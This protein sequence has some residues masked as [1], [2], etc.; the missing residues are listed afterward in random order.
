[1]INKDPASAA[2]VQFTLNGFTPSQFKSYTISQSS[3]NAIVASG[4][5]AWLGTQSFAPY[6]ATLLVIAGSQP[7]TPSA[8]WDLN[9]ESVMVPAGLTVT[10]APKLI[11]NTGT[12][13]LNS[14]QPDSSSI[15]MSISAATITS[16]QNGAITVRA[17]ST[18]GFYHFTVTGTD[19]SGVA[20]KQ[21]GWIVVS[22]PEASLAKQGDNQSGMHGTTLTLSVTL[23]PGQSGGSATGA[24]IL[25]TTNAGSLS[26]RIVP[27]DSS[28]NASVTLTLPASTGTVTVTAEGPYG[29]GHPV[30]TFTETSQ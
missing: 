24:S 30:A 15:S 16:T 11:S 23:N 2:E 6:T 4:Q 10:L 25:F 28:G 5:Q 1:V 14:A 13:T 12:V 20:Q 27:T 18:P 26:Q 17:G 8:E 9:P 3:P 21:G 22:N 29:L 7:T 19:G